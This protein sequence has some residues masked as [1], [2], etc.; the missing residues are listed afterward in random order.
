[1]AVLIPFSFQD[2]IEIDMF[3]YAVALVLE[4][5]AL[6]WLRIKKPEMP[7]PYLVPYGIPGVI[8]ISVPPVAL[9]LAS[10]ALSNDATRYASLGGIAAGLVVYWWKCRLSAARETEPA[11][12]L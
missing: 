6:I 3:L 7:R 11:A 2:L 4:F 10:I 1:L 9:C 5:G 12:M 8:A